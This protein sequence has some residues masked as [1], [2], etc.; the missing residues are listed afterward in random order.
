MWLTVAVAWVSMV[1]AIRNTQAFVD[2]VEPSL[3]QSV[4]PEGEYRIT[5]VENLQGCRLLAPMDAFTKQEI[6]SESSGT[7]QGR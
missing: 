7:M 4:P 6:A 2:T 1:Y 5:R 3:A